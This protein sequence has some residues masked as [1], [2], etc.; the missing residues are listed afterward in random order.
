MLQVADH[1]SMSGEHV[2]TTPGLSFTD[3]GASPT[4]SEPA[5]KRRTAGQASTNFE[6]S[7]KLL[8]DLK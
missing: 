1:D 7:L 6:I 3:A 2:G 4:S 5:R 8:R